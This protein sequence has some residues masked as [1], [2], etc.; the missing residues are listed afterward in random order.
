MKK[1]TVN[2][3]QQT[4]LAKLDSAIGVT[5]ASIRAHEEALRNLDAK[6]LNQ[7]AEFHR[8]STKES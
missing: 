2:R 6:L 1:K 5:R 4:E 8:Q 7:L 3:R